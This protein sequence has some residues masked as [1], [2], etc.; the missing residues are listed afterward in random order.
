[1]LSLLLYLMVLSDD[2]LTTSLSLYCKQ[3]IP[4]LCPFKVRTNSQEDVLHTYE[5]IIIPLIG[6]IEI[7]ISCK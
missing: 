5:K 1:M 6:S 7:S 3:A 2:P 4:L